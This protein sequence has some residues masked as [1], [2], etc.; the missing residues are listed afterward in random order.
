M[1]TLLCLTLTQ[2]T[3]ARVLGYPEKVGHRLLQPARF[4][5]KNARN[6]VRTICFRKKLLN[7]PD[8]I[9]DELV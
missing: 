4:M 5:K 3:S 6:S 7:H 8:H 2:A 9:P 1:T